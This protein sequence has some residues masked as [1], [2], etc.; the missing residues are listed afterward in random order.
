MSPT[1]HAESFEKI[2]F[3]GSKSMEMGLM[4]WWDAQFL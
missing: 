2:M 3:G 4:T 1:A